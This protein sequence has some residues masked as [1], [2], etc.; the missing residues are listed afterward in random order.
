MAETTSP[1]SGQD[2]P[3][4]Q[5]LFSNWLAEQVR[6]DRLPLSRFL[7]R[8]FGP[9]KY[10]YLSSR[11]VAW[12]AGVWKGMERKFYTREKRQGRASREGNK[13]LPGDYCISRF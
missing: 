11:T 7:A 2:E 6:W 8:D 1:R 4:L 3:S 12:A 13:R 5:I 9:D 10:L